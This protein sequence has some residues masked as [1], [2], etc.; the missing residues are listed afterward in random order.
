MRIDATATKVVQHIQNPKPPAE[1]KQEVFYFIASSSRVGLRR[2][3]WEHEIESSNLS[4]STNIQVCGVINLKRFS[5]SI[6]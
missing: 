3:P 1:K 2:V 4:Y 6:L 5:N